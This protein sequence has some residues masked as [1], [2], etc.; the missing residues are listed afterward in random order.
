LISGRKAFSVKWKTMGPTETNCD[1]RTGSWIGNYSEDIECG[2][3]R[4]YLSC[5]LPI[6]NESKIIKLQMRFYKS[7]NPDIQPPKMEFQLSV[8]QDGKE[9]KSEINDQKKDEGCVY[10]IATIKYFETDKEFTVKW[11]INF[12]N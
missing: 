8:E 7:D 1:W 3:G 6:N 2:N 12:A 10:Q 4:I 11:K 9:I 5:Y